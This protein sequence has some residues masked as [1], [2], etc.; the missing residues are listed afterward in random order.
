MQIVTSDVKEFCELV[1]ISFNASLFASQLQLSETDGSIVVLGLTSRGKSTLVNELC[2]LSLCP[3]DARAETVATQRITSGTPFAKGQLETGE[4]VLLSTSPTEFSARLSRAFR[5]NV[6]HAEFVGA[7]RLP[8]GVAIVDTPGV[9]DGLRHEVWTRWRNVPAAGAVVVVS[10]PGAFSKRDRLIIEE[11]E[12]I[13]GSQVVVAVKATDSQIKNDDIASMAALVKEQTGLEALVI[14]NH[15]SVEPWG[16]GKTAS[17]DAAIENL[18]RQAEQ[19]ARR[20]HEK[21]SEMMSLVATLV[22]RVDVQRLTHLRKSLVLAKRISPELAIA[23]RARISRIMEDEVD[24]G[25]RAQMEIETKRQAALS[26]EVDLLAELLP[27]P[28]EIEI[29]LHGEAIAELMKL[30]DDGSETAAIVLGRYVCLD[31]AKKRTFGL[32]MQSLV[33]RF[34]WMVAAPMLSE[35]VFED[36]E[37]ELVLRL[38]SSDILDCLAKSDGL[39]R[40]FRAKSLEYLEAAHKF[41]SSIVLRDMI[42]DAMCLSR[43]DA[44]LEVIRDSRRVVD[45]VMMLQR[46]DQL[47]HWSLIRHDA[48]QS[49]LLRTRF[50][51]NLDAIEVSARRRAVQILERRRD[52]ILKSPIRNSEEDLLYELSNLE[53]ILG[54]LSV[55]PHGQIVEELRSGGQLELW[56][57]KC[58]ASKAL[59][60]KRARR[61]RIVA[62]SAFTISLLTSITTVVFLWQ[63][64]LPGEFAWAVA[65][66]LIGIR[67]SWGAVFDPVPWTWRFRYPQYAYPD[68]RVVNRQTMDLVLFDG[69]SSIR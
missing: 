8:T 25:R 69:P 33:K 9:N 1:G 41:A 47:R 26:R 6:L 58:V 68:G 50:A 3:V 66:G 67:L 62:G 7:T 27:A 65:A 5:P 2:G 61:S 30:V 17:L 59:A 36:V 55:P 16:R 13:F 34:G 18:V 40:F 37:I 46:I 21:A 20:A 29:A 56:L 48:L 54:W 32:D 23:V 49:A 51:E 63:S 53:E 19:S 43:L 28:D 35:Y 45:V 52:D 31:P 38:D 60:R 22:A 12:A 44:T 4:D 11:A 39:R 14:P 15:V 24:A 64:V 42:M 10:V 57:K